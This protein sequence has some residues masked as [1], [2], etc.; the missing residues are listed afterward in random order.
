MKK[1]RMMCLSCVFVLA[2]I[3]SLAFAHGDFILLYSLF[4]VGVLHLALGLYLIFSK[5]F[6]GF[7]LPGILLYVTNISISWSWALE[8]GGPSFPLM[9]IGLIG[10]PLLTFLCLMWIF[11]NLAKKKL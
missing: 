4:S 3:P 2:L 10:G 6:T 9:Y 7:R 11:G 8:Y 5:R 1:K